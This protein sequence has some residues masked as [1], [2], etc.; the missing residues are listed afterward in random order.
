VPI[1]ADAF[2]D[3][4]RSKHRNNASQT[5]LLMPVLRA[6]SKILYTLCKIRGEKI[7][8]RFLS[9]D[10][11]H[12]E[13]L[14]SAIEAGNP[15]DARK[16]SGDEIDNSQPHFQAAAS[17]INRYVWEW[18]ERYITLLWLSQLLLAP[19]DLST[20]SSVNTNDEVPPVEN[21][22]WPPKTPGVTF[23][24]LPLALRYLSSSGK[25]RDAA[26]T[27][28]VR[29]AMRR[30]MQELGV[31]HAL[32]QWA[33]S[34]FDPNSTVPKSSYHY[35]GVLSFLAG[36]LNA[37]MSTSDMDPY[38]ISIFEILQGERHKSIM[39]V[40]HASVLARKVVLKVLRNISVIV[41]DSLS[42]FICD[43]HP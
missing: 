37:S 3:S 42:Y 30:D 14:L 31:L 16:A 32:I 35:I 41:R 4:L 12:L 6:I 2:I 26:K 39:N 24:V 5:K 36:I 18:E 25:E 27:L 38:L 43:S 13:L 9:T 34:C 28:L 23:R 1:L 20:L 19:F 21:L 22:V 15:L 17:T 10:T 33:I 7:I 40:V 29:I 8:V 11:K